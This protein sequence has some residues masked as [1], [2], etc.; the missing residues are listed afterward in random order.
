LSFVKAIEG[1]VVRFVL[2]LCSL[3]ILGYW[4]FSLSGGWTQWLLGLGSPAVFAVIWGVLIAPKAK[5]RLQD[6]LRFGIEVVLFVCVAAALVSAGGET[7]VAVFA[8][9]GDQPGR[10]CSYSV[11]DAR[12][13]ADAM[14]GVAPSEYYAGV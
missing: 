13:E 5:V 1:S 3:V 14:A 8:R 6:P 11:R 9:R 7:L 10:K 12:F 4:G 2:E